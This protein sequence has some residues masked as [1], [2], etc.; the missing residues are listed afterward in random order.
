M[1][2]PLLF[3]I[4]LEFLAGV[5]RQV[6]EI[7]TIH[8]RKKEA[9]TAAVIISSHQM[10]SGDCSRYAL[11]PLAVTMMPGIPHR[12]AATVNKVFLF[13]CYLYFVKSYFFLISSFSESERLL[14]YDFQPGQKLICHLQNLPARESGLESCFA[15]I[16]HVEHL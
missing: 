16:G 13:I 10:S 6:I 8:I 14:K 5:I 15:L 11:K 12:T 7:K 4:T 3:N 2:S 1:L 9:R